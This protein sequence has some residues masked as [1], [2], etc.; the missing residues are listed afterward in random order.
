MQ[1]YHY[2]PIQYRQPYSARAHVYE[3]EKRSLTELRQLLVLRSRV[4]DHI[5]EL[6]SVS[7]PLT[8]VGTDVT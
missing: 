8:D 4:F 3:K 6:I 1:S 7:A 5:R 2:I